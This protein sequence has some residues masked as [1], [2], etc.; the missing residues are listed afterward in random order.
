MIVSRGI[1]VL[2][3]LL[4]SCATQHQDGSKI[5]VVA[6]MAPVPL[7]SYSPDVQQKD[8]HE[9]ALEKCEEMGY[10]KVLYMHTV[11]SGD[12]NISYFEC[13]FDAERSWN[14]SIKKGEWPSGFFAKYPDLANLTFQYVGDP[15][16]ARRPEALFVSQPYGHDETQRRVLMV[17]L[18]QMQFQGPFMTQIL[19]GVSCERRKYWYA[20]ESF[21][22]ASYKNGERQVQRV[23]RSLDKEPTGT[24]IDQWAT[25]IRENWD[26]ACRD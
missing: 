7:S 14:D 10:N 2:T 16:N 5:V 12:T 19:Y 9:A 26:I 24:G 4:A 18:F 8:K 25:L 3:F 20:I 17:W 15:S 22:T 1:L 23:L 21:Y 13:D 11:P 6:W